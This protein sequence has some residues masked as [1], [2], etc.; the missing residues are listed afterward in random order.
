MTGSAPPII[1]GFNILQ[2]CSFA[3]IR[4]R[5][6]HFPSLDYKPRPSCGSDLDQWSNS[7]IRIASRQA[8]LQK[9]D[10]NSHWQ[11]QVSGAVCI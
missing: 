10:S 5:L 9:P 8:P 6:S 4:V 1:Q 2:W 3:P 7:G 11:T